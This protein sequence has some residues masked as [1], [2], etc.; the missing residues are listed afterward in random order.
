[1]SFFVT[2]FANDQIKT[3]TL[4]VLN[5]SNFFATHCSI[6]FLQQIDTSL[7]KTL[8]KKESNPRPLTSLHLRWTEHNP[9]YS[10][11]RGQPWRQT[12]LLWRCQT[13]QRRAN[14]S[15]SG[16]GSIRLRRRGSFA[17][18]R[19]RDESRGRGLSCRSAILERVVK[20]VLAK[21]KTYRCKKCRYLTQ[22]ILICDLRIGTLSFC[23]SRLAFDL[24]CNNQRGNVTTT[25]F[26]QSLIRR[27]QA[28][29]I[30]TQYPVS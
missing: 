18:R 26:D 5:I 8:G 28:D 3:K 15:S 6:V 1:M 24:Q 21:W 4:S 11:F 13:I 9:H 2:T 27:N 7:N 16:N 25:D 30:A 10:Q 14:N 20:L 19:R 12:S 23:V 17:A 22:A 29:L